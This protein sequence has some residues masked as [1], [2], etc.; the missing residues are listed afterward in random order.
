MADLSALR[1]KVREAL[2]VG[3]LPAGFPTRIL[4]GAGSGSA[5]VICGD[6]IQHQEMELE[7]EFAAPGTSEVKTYKLHPMC[8][9]A[10]ELEYRQM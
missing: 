6:V 9:V 2:Q 10:W 5:C 8:C 7:L 4:G 1:S 3:K